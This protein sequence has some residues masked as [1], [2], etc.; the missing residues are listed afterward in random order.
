MFRRLP[1]RVGECARFSPRTA[2]G[3]NRLQVLARGYYQKQLPLFA[4]AD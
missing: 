4:D 3:A 1:R 2:L